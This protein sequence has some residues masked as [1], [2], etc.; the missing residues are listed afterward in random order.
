M[1]KTQFLII[2][3]LIPDLL[4]ALEAS[5]QKLADGFQPSGTISVSV[6]SFQKA[7]DLIR[8]F[9]SDSRLNFDYGSNGCIE[10]TQLMTSTAAK[11]DLELG[12]VFVHGQ[13]Y[14]DNSTS[15]LKS[16]MPNDVYDWKKHVA[17]VV[18]VKGTKVIQPM[19]LDPALSMEPM[20][21]EQFRSKITAKGLTHFANGNLKPEPHIE[22]FYYGSRFQY[23]FYTKYP[24]KIPTMD[25]IDFDRVAERTLQ[26]IDQADVPGVSSD[27]VMTDEAYCEKYGLFC[28]DTEKAKE[29]RNRLELEASAY[30]VKPQGCETKNILKVSSSTALVPDGYSKDGQIELSV[31]TEPQAEELFSKMK[32]NSKIKFKETARSHFR[33]HLMVETAADSKL[34]AGKV[35]IEGVLFTKAFSGNSKGDDSSFRLYVAPIIIVEK[36]DRSLVK[37]ILDP[38]LFDG[39]VE[40]QKLIEAVQAPSASIDQVPKVER[41]YCS[42]RYQFDA[43][44]DAKVKY[45]PHDMKNIYDVLIKPEYDQLEI[46]TKKIEKNF[47]KRTPAKTL[48]K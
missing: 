9:K 43:Y 21:I 1:K 47:Q 3:L 15:K 17:P 23:D 40:L 2:G 27:F 14:A 20:T 48:K 29:I 41:I 36:S 13:L 18:F 24:A 34:N 39:P 46:S 31:V 33:A 4:F 22:K 25:M 32:A 16:Q 37:T 10:R 44:T 11:I 8:I 28:A 30:E 6:V 5:F 12:K 42:D 19:V 26:L 7:K 45:P 38:S 35:F